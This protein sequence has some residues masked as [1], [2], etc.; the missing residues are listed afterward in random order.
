MKTID[1]YCRITVN[2]VTHDIEGHRL[3]Y[4]NVVA[5]T[6]QHGA[7]LSV[8]YHGRVTIDSER[9]EKNGTLIPGESVKI[10]DGMRF[11]AYH[12]GNA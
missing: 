11:S 10:H 6:G 9:Y 3:S 5:L 12:T 8:V 4:E 7:H 1:A 2:G